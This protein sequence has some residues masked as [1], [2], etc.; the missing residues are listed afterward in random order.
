MW[1][2]D[3]FAGSTTWNAVLEVSSIPY[4]TSSCLH[5]TYCMGVQTS[6]QRGVCELGN[7]FISIILNTFY[8]YMY[9]TEVEHW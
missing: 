9:G 7:C 4:V 5:P 1:D 3:P 8:Y 6:E 2:T